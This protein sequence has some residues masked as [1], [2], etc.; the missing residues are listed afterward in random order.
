MAITKLDLTKAVSGTLP[1]GNAPSGSI[2]QIKSATK[3]DTQ[4]SSSQTFADVTDMSVSITPSSTSSK[5]L[6]FGYCNVS[7]DNNTAKSAIQLVRGTTN[8]LIGDAAG[9]RTRVTGF[10][11]V[12]QDNLAPVPLTFNFL[13]SPS[14]TSATTYKIQFARLDGAGTVYVNRSDLDQDTGIMGRSASTI[15]IMEIAG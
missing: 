9:S 12:P 1:D 7:Y 15:T 10:A 6:A 8:I 14:T 5:I 13:D 2:I 11:Y 4:S 3:T